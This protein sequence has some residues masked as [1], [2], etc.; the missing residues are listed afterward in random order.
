MFYKVGPAGYFGGVVK[1]SKGPWFREFMVED[2]GLDW[3][4]T[5]LNAEG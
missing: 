4:Y 3:Y 2:D 1:I 5:F